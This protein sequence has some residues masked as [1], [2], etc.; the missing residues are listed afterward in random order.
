MKLKKLDIKGFG[1]FQN[2]ILPFDAGMNVI[3]GSNEAGKTTLQNF[4]KGMLFGLKGGRKAKDGTLPPARQYRPWNGKHFSGILEYTLDDGRK[5]IAGRN[6]EKNTVSIEDEYSNNITGAFPAGREEGSRFAEEHLGISESSFERTVFISQMQSYVDAEG[7]K[8]LAERLLNLR[9]SGDEEI[10]FR[11]AMKALKDAQLSHVGSDRSTTR[12]LNLLEARLE[13]ALKEEQEFIELHESRM[14]IFLELD[15]FKQQDSQLKVQLEQAYKTKEV[16]LAKLK[17][18]EQEKL[19]QQLCRYDGELVRAREDMHK[20]DMDMAAIRIKM[21]A[22][23]GYNV[24][25]RNDANVMS[26]DHTRYQLLEKELAELEQEKIENEGKLAQA[27][28]MQARY[29]FFERDRDEIEKTLNR[30]L[31]QKSNP[32]TDADKGIP[33]EIP[34]LGKKIWF[35]SG[36]T[37]FFAL[38]ILADVFLLRDLFPKGMNTLVIILSTLLLT[39]FSGMLY[40]NAVKPK[41]KEREKAGQNNK[42]ENQRLLLRWMQEAQVDNLNDLIRLKALFENSRQLL[43]ELKEEQASLKQKEAGT[44]TRMQELKMKMSSKLS[45]V[46]LEA[47]SGIFF[48]EAVHTWKENLEA[49]MVMLPAL[50]EIEG[51]Y[52]ATRQREEGILREASILCGEDVTSPEAMKTIISRK[53]LKLE[54][55]QPEQTQ[56]DV[57]LEQVNDN[58]E[59]LHKILRQ[60]ELKMNTLA[61]R[62]ESLPDTETLQQAHETVQ[63][64]LEEKARMIFLA[65]A[66]DTATQVLAEAG[67]VIQ[68]DYV[69]MLNHEMSAILQSITGEKYCNLK[70]DD[71]LNLKLQPEDMTETVLPEQLS[72][73]TSDQVYLALRLATVRMVEKKAEKLPL[74]L[75]EPFAQYDET[76]TRNALMLLLQESRIRQILLFT[77]KKREV[78]ILRELSGKTQVRIIDLDIEPISIEQ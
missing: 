66:L 22:I 15:Q 9:Q 43:G 62:L 68:R 16:I 5:F 40:L 30:V 33:G 49:Y 46:N 72:S 31:Y 70:A 54:K 21:E 34:R 35:P 1:R 51:A 3:Y 27:E 65:K 52:A 39:V 38:V 47:T 61:T 42:A 76:R 44:K 41:Q 56:S 26:S 28:K 24:F 74:F 50:K 12:P 67:L 69:P 57:T 19:C 37:L 11:K 10:S 60:N 25:S 63:S 78:E 77:C 45:R 36:A 8:I 29:A 73:G 14:N 20:L 75:D 17:N 71:N 18:T 53:R 55:M 64:L 48:D 7:R 59:A 2:R 32:V 6:F 4:I 23:S 13:S 58:I